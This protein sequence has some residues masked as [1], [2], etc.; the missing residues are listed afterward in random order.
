MT[1]MSGAAIASS[2]RLPIRRRMVVLVA[3]AG[4]GG[5]LFLPLLS[6]GSG[7]P[8][9]AVA[10]FSLVATIVTTLAIWPGLRCADAL[11][12]PMPYLRRLDGV[13]AS[14]PRRALA[15]SAMWG[16]ALGLAGA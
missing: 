8:L 9:T 14:I 13:A 15:V 1:V 5:L 16:T 6:A 10:G 3:I 4:A 2:A 12:L 7:Q 11:G